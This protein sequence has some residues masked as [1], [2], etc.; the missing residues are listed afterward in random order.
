MGMGVCGWRASV[1]HFKGVLTDY[2]EI[3]F[4]YSCCRSSTKSTIWIHKLW[5]AH[6]AIHI[7]NRQQGYNTLTRLWCQPCCTGGVNIVNMYLTRYTHSVNTLGSL[8]TCLYYSEFVCMYYFALQSN[9]AHKPFLCHKQKVLWG[10]QDIAPPKSLLIN[11]P[12]KR[13]K[14]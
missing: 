10:S 2:A 12:N 5:T 11:K 9:P 14:Q 3:P 4:A 1:L 8:T 6:E 7:V 13:N